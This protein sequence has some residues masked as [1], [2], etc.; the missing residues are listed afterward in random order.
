MP[1]R[2]N[3]FYL[4]KSLFYLLRQNLCVDLC[5]LDVGMSEHLGHYFDGDSATECY[6]GGEGVSAYV[7]CDVLAYV[8][9]GPDKG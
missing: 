8:G 1:L 3:L 5:G 6:G 9:F 2:H 4:L 7:G